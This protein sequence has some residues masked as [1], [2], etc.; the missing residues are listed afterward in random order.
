MVQQLLDPNGALVR[1]LQGASRPGKKDFYN[2]L[3]KRID[4]FKDGNFQTW[5]Y[6]LE[7]AVAYL[8]TDVAEIMKVSEK[9]SNKFDLDVAESDPDNGILNNEAFK[10]ANLEL[11]FALTEKTEGESFDIVHNVAEQNGGEAWRR[12]CVRF[13]SRTLGKQIHSTRKVINPPKIK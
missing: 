3:G 12:L 7:S 2:S 9:F 1:G 10:Q 6:K 5:K 8:S 4:G 13:D 11:Y